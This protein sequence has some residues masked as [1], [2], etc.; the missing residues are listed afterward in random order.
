MG[1]TGAVPPPLLSNDTQAR[2]PTSGR[3]HRV[4]T[5]VSRRLRESPAL[6]PAPMLPVTAADPHETTSGTYRV[7]RG[8]GGHTD[9]TGH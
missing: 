7:V 4:A 8:G 6:S 5:L 2:R 1:G 3:Q 9:A